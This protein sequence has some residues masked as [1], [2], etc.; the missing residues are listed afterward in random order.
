MILGKQIDNIDQRL[1]DD[2]EKFCSTLTFVY[3]HVLKP[4]LDT[5][6]LTQALGELMGYKQIFFFYAYFF[7]MN[8]ILMAIKPN[9]SRLV[10]ES[11]RLEGFY[12]ADHTRIVQYSEEIAFVEGSKREHE[13]VSQSF[14]K[15]EKHTD[16]DLWTHFWMDLIDGYVMKY[17]GTMCAYSAIIPSVYI[18]WKG[19]TTQQATQHYLTATNML[20]SLGTS[21]KDIILSYKEVAKL[22]GLTNRI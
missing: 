13:L 2:V 6:F 9:F 17:G 15:L 4:T 1:T 3:G 7:G 16:R 14:R 5:L 11:Q 20:L 21:L 19:M 18:N 10:T 8:Q 22:E 12:R